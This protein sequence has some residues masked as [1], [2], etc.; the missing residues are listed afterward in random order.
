MQLIPASSPEPFIKKYT[1]KLRYYYIL[2]MIMLLCLAE[3]GSAQK[4]KVKKATKKEILKPV[5]KESEPPVVMEKITDSI[6]EEMPPMIAYPIKSQ[7]LEDDIADAAR[8]A[9]EKK[10]Y[11]KPFQFWPSIDTVIHEDAQTYLEKRRSSWKNYSTGKPSSIHKPVLK[12]VNELC[13]ILENNKMDTVRYYGDGW[14]ERKV[15]DSNGN[16]THLYI[17]FEDEKTKQDSAYLTTQYFYDGHQL[18]LKSYYWWE[19]GQKEAEEE[20]E[21]NDKGQLWKV[22]YTSLDK[23]GDEIIEEGRGF[24]TL[25]KYEDQLQIEE[26]YERLEDAMNEYVLNETIYKTLGKGGVV[27]ESKKIAWPEETPATMTTYQYDTKGNKIFSGDQES[28]YTYQYNEYGDVVKSIYK[29]ADPSSSSTTTYTYTYDQHHNWL[30]REEVNMD[31][32]QDTTTEKVYL[33]KR[34]LS[35]HDK[36]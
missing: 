6:F 28:S 20:L 1:M 15:Y 18:T 8:P 13:Y 25:Y 17:I 29:T 26:N 32:D 24:R 7:D 9:R 27:V 34:E 10:S 35:Y 12:S 11:D 22:Y 36:D 14:N 31:K 2:P 16:L 33:W 5:K 19:T 3:S 21:Y 23:N 4:K 30:T